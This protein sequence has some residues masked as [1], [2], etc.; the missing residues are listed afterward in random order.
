MKFA[1]AVLAAFAAWSVLWVGG[2]ALLVKFFP[3]SFREDKTTESAGMLVGLL[4]LS[5]VYSLLSG[6]LAARIGGGLGPVYA[7]AGLTLAVG[8]AVQASYWN[9]LPLWYHLLFLGLL[10]P[11]ILLGGRLGAS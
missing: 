5:V 11:A 2:N 8:I 3:D 9:K 7:H 4:A 6:Y 1:L 10:A